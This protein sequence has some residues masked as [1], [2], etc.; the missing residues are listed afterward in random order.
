MFFDSQCIMPMGICGGVT[1]EWELTGQ[2]AKQ[3]VYIQPDIDASALDGR[4]Q[5]LNILEYETT[6]LINAQNHAFP[7]TLLQCQ[8]SSAKN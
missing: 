4:K 3:T 5:I 1:G 7:M 2:L 6:P 8:I